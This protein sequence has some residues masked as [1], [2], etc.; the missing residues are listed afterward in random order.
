MFI[1]ELTK[2][3]LERFKSFRK[4]NVCP[5]CGKMVDFNDGFEMLKVKY[6]VNTYY[7]FIHTNC[8][9]SKISRR[10]QNGKKSQES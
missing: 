9:L 7:A 4:N 3:E 1:G 2:Y 8:I 10:Y 6:A 5:I